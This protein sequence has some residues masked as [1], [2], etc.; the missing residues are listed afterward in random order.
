MTDMEWVSVQERAGPALK[1]VLWFLRHT[2]SRPGEARALKWADVFLS[3]SVCRLK[4]FKGKNQ[5]RDGVRVRVIPLTPVVIQVLRD[6]WQARKPKLD[7]PVFLNSKGLPWS[8]NALRLAMHRACEVVNNQPGERVVCYTIRHTGATKAT[9][10]GV[11]DRLLAGIMGHSSTRTTARYQHLGE[12]DLVRV[13][14]QAT[15]GAETAPPTPV[16][17]PWPGPRQAPTPQIA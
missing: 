4:S 10:N 3:E 1:N 9:L 8:S 5:R 16:A 2:I 13:M 6:W 15:K 12:Q 17:L 7:A 11:A 14:A